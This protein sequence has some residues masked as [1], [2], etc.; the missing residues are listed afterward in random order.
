MLIKSKKKRFTFKII[1][2]KLL[3]YKNIKYLQTV[4]KVYF[5]KLK[6]FPHLKL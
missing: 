5:D 1:K 2:S 6:R 4:C 3:N